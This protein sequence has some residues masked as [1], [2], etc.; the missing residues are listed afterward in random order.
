MVGSEAGEK[1]L[2]GFRASRVLAPEIVLL[3]SLACLRKVTRRRQ[4][5]VMA[6]V[7]CLESDLEPVFH[8]R[9]SD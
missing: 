9:K 5:G 2:N 4:T 3:G 1:L 6:V 7:V 8:K